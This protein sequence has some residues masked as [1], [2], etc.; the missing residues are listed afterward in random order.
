M[1]RNS[2]RNLLDRA[3]GTLRLVGLMSGTSVDGIDAALVEV[4]HDGTALSW[5]LLAFECLPWEPELRAA[6]LKAFQPDISLPFLVAL[7]S[8]LGEAFAEAAIHL[9]QTSGWDLSAVDAVASHGQTIWHQPQP[10]AVGGGWGT[11]TLQLGDGHVIA[12]KTGCVVVSDFRRADMALGGQGAPLVPFVDFALFA[13]RFEGRLVVNLGGIANL[14]WLPAGASSAGVRAFDTGPGSMVLDALALHFTEGREAFDREGMLAGQ[15]QPDQH[16]LKRLLE[17]RYF[18]TPPPK[19]TGREDFGLH[20]A[21]ELI[22]LADAEGYR[23]VDM[24]ATV[25]ALTV[26]TIARACEQWILPHGPV[27][28]VI[29]GGGGVHNATLVRWLGERLAP[30]QL[31]THAAFGLPDDAKEAVAFAILAYETLNGRPANIPTATGANGPAILGR[32][33]LP[34][35]AS[36]I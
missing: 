28:T 30:A 5:R 1:N 14:T 21:A 8:R 27:Q 15:G 35:P 22:A 3:D 12:A 18:A 24:M 36:G 9:V 29:L 23:G 17:H 16:L 25:T 31:T 11:G 26:E 20:Y 10:F 6:I 7:D 13:H 4:G 33:S 2:L 34:P 19:S 32:I